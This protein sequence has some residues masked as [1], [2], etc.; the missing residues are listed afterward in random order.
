[1]RK[2]IEKELTLHYI[3]GFFQAKLMTNL[4]SH[5]NAAPHLLAGS[6]GPICDVSRLWSPLWASSC[7]VKTLFCGKDHQDFRRWLC[8]VGHTLDFHSRPRTFVCTDVLHSYGVP[9]TAIQR[10]DLV[11]HKE[12]HPQTRKSASAS[13]NC[14]LL[15]CNIEVLLILS[16]C[17]HNLKT[18]LLC[19]CA[20][21]C[22]H[23]AKVKGKLHLRL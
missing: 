19:S 18:V 23:A 17:C 4:N 7:A 22:K 12:T 11:L 15:L 1:M 21:M 9:S 14:G 2:R 10:A 3:S 6:E 16:L 20:S 5:D 13:S 8:I